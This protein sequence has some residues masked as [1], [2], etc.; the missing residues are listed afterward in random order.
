MT[1]P[2]ADLGAWLGRL[3]G[4][5]RLGVAFAAGAFSAL[6]FEPFE[7]FPLLLLGTAV[8]VL[9]FDGAAKQ[10]HPVRAGALAGWA[11][12][13]GQFLV[14]LHW[15]VY[16][17]LV[18]PS[19]HAWQIP[20]VAV[21]L[22]GGLAL[23]IALAGAGA[24]LLW[25]EGPGRVF[26]FALC[27]TLAEWLR[28]HILTGFPWNIAGYGWGASLGVLQSTAVIG[29]YGLTLLTLL[30]GASL[31]EFFAVRP[32]WHMPAALAG[33][34]V[35]LALG[36]NLRL[37]LTRVA[38]VPNVSLRL[39]QPDVPQ[40]EKYERRYL[41][42]NWQ[43]LVALTLA[44]GRPTI[45]IWP[46]A[47]AIGGPP[48]LL[49]RQPMALD[50]IAQLTAG[51]LL[52]TGALRGERDENGQARYYNSFYIFG[53]DGR[54]IATYDKAHLVPFGEYL[55]FEKTLGALGLSKLTEM[56]GSFST[57]DGPHTYDLP[58]AP[59][60]D[61]LICYEILFPEQVVGRR[62]PGWIVN[63]TDD[64]WFGP[65]AGP[66]QHLLVAQ[67]RA[68]EQGLPVIR[69]ANTG[70]SAII[71]PLGRIRSQLGLGRLGTVDGRLPAA[72]AAPPYARLGDWLFWLLVCT[73]AA[74][75]WLS[76]K[77]K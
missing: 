73:N 74:L 56:S 33:L 67:V 59:A 12:G 18:E 22:P 61:P 37:A 17:F 75:T 62:R 35:V 8:L 48:Y 70:I 9:L 64:S 6:G 14:G 54:L 69:A 21:L 10:A 66:R 76:F 31:A 38:D 47:A 27:Y 44:P 55:P 24:M 42:R 3:G 58:G 49:A 41:A 68:I 77:G 25:R 16:A 51:R 57:G 13:F 60:V 4:W 65:W 50:V 20:F 72:I 1:A 52:M 45:V 46:E 39:V 19:Q 36:G 7:V 63:V 34:F 11:F 23:F 15:I 40:A 43:R 5:R 2:L 28:G 32:K 30:F 26:W 53:G 29:V 71:D